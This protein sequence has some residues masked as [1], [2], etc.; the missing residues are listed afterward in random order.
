MRIVALLILA[1]GLAF[2]D[3][4]SGYLVNSSCYA[5][6]QSNTN[7]DP[8]TV[9][10]D[11]TA[12]IRQCRPNAKTRHFAV[13]TNTW[14]SLKFDDAGNAKAAGLARQSTSWPVTVTV[15]GTRTGNTIRVDTI[16]PAH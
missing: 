4:W 6:E 2:A 9:D 15:S 14:N 10:R 7:K 1:A 16:S 12:E 13:V 3:S 11:M 8:T 5:N